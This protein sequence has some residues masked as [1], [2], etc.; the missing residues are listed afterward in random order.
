MNHN[1]SYQDIGKLQ[2]MYDNHANCE[3]R[4]CISLLSLLCNL[5]DINGLSFVVRSVRNFLITWNLMLTW[6][7]KRWSMTMYTRETWHENVAM[8]CFFIN[9]IQSSNYGEFRDT[10]FTWNPEIILSR[11]YWSCGIKCELHK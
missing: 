6:G 9:T 3:S 2:G 1:I 8:Q 5:K 11:I 4:T 10:R 7:D